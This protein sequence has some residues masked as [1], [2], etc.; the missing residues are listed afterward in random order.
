MR[1]EVDAHLVGKRLGEGVE[2]GQGEGAAR[3][4]VRPP[5]RACS[6]TRSHHHLGRH[7]DAGA[8]DLELARTLG[9]AL[10][11]THG[12][13]DDLSHASAA[14][15]CSDLV[16]L[17]R[18]SVDAGEELT[19][20]GQHGGCFAQRRQD[21]ADVVQE[22]PIGPDDEHAAARKLLAVR[23]KQV[24]GAMQRDDGLATAG[25]ALH[26]EDARQRRAHD[27]V[28]LRLHRG[29]D[30]VHAPRAPSGQGGHEDAATLHVVGDDPR[31]AVR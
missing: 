19:G 27:G 4:V 7:D 15:E 9:D 23:V 3:D 24:G 20:G 18:A 30:V 22:D 29:D 17:P 25:T 11:L 2:E 21:L 13:R 8:A 10:P 1:L 31:A 28:L 5:G 14:L 6:I 12:T 26:H 16:G